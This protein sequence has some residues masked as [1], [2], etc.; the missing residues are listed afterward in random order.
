M[1][2]A[3]IQ[4]V[5]YLCATIRWSMS[6]RNCATAFLIHVAL[7]VMPSGGATFSVATEAKQPTNLSLS[8]VDT[9]RS[10]RPPCMHGTQPADYYPDSIYVVTLGSL[11][12]AVIWFLCSLPRIMGMVQTRA[13]EALKL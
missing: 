2:P 7:Y 5:L 4:V 10:P 12:R 3:Q 11:M 1:L 13:F 9:A 6:D 8:F